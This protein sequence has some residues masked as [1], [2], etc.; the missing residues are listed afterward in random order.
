MLWWPLVYTRGS[1]LTAELWDGK[2]YS[3]PGMP[4]EPI[5][6][7][8]LG[9]TA[10]GKSCLAMHLAAKFRGEIVNCDSQQMYRYFDLGTAKPSPEERAAIPH[11]FIDIL[12]PEE[13]FAAGEYM[14]SARQTLAEVAGRD[15]LPIVVAGTGFYFRALLYGL[16]PGPAR[17][18]ELRRRL[19]EKAEQKGREHLHRLLK[20]LD[21]AAAEKIHARDTHKVI[22]ALE[23]CLTARRPISELFRQGRQALEGFRMLKVGL[24]PPRSEL[25]ERINQRA[26]SLFE[27]GLLEEVQDI[28]ARGVSPAA[29]PFQAIGYRQAL[30]FLEGRL[31]R[32]EAIYHVQTKTRQYAKRQITWFRTE[33][34]VQ[35]FSG[36]GTDPKIQM[37]VQQYLSEQL[38]VAPAR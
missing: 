6:V 24:N 19:Q 23:V 25:Y 34:G 14:R 1:D 33:T 30:D 28:L 32:E 36:F 17:N 20:R 35:W 22:R 16:F 4:S 11:H 10:S 18:P 38:A 7:A 15:K 29:S 31:T 21:A 5:V 12:N 13:Q 8:I 26:R 2:C 37:E 3:L 27:R 9:P